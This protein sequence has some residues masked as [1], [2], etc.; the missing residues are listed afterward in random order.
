MPASA[1]SLALAPAATPPAPRPALRAVPPPRPRAARAPWSAR[2]GV[3]ALGL[4]AGFLLAALASLP[5]GGE[6]I[7][8][9]G[10]LALASAAVAVPALLRARAVARRRGRAQNR[11]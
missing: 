2:I 10:W 4:C 6:V 7:A 8:G 3:Y 1:R 11:L 9:Q 5:G